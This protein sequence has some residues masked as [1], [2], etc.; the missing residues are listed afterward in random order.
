MSIERIVKRDRLIITFG[1]AGITAISWIYMFNMPGGMMNMD[2][3]TRIC[4][5]PHIH[6]WNSLN[7]FLIFSM[8]T[9]MMIAMMVPSESPIV[10]MFAA[11]NR[12]RR[13]LRQPFVS[14]GTFLLGYVVAWT[15]FSASATLTQRG[16]QAATLLS[17]TMVINSSILGG[18]LLS[19]AGI[20]QLTRL[21]YACLS[22]CRSPLGFLLNEW[23]EGT[24]G[25]FIMGFKH[26]VYCIGCCWLL[27][28][29]MFVAGVMNLLWMVIITVLV[30]LEK[31]VPGGFWISR[32]A[33]LLLIVWGM[34]MALGEIF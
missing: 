18:A 8:W 9:V 1:L 23:R 3:G 19:F 6:A 26:G 17:G 10:L 22:R 11:I 15:I 12:E 30:F 7:L 32:L 31:V 13:R 16:L 33:G 34:W 20:F 4:C 5:N 14:T 27:M 21:K 29:L 28:G 24:F 25:A 2:R